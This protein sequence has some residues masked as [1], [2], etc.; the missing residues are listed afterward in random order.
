MTYFATNKGKRKPGLGIRALFVGI[1][2]MCLAIIY[3]TSIHYSLEQNT[4]LRWLFY[5]RGEINAPKDISIVALNSSAAERMGYS[6]HSYTWPRS[7]Y[8]E[9]LG[10]L[11]R[12]NAKLIVLDIAFTEARKEQEDGPF[13]TAL[14]NSNNVILYKYL[15]RHQVATSSGVIDIEEEVPPLQRFLQHALGAGY[16]VLPKE[17]GVLTHA[18]LFLELSRG[19]EASQPVLAFLATQSHV[20]LSR[21]WQTLSGAPFDSSMPI[22][23]QATELYKLTDTNQ[24]TKIP[25]HLQNLFSVFAQRSPLTINFYGQPQSLNHIDIDR[26]LSLDDQE[27]AEWFAGKIVYVGYME[28]KQTEQQDAYS[29]VY[30]SSTGVD[31]SGVEISATVLGNLLNQEYIRATPHYIQFAIT[32]VAFFIGYFSIRLGAK[33][34]FLAQFIC[35][36]TYLM[37]C[38]IL[39][40]VKYVWPPILLP[41]IALLTANLTQFLHNF[42]NNRRKLNQLRFALAQFLPPSAASQLGQSIMSLEKQ[43][44]VVSGVALITDIKGYTRLS[45]TLAPEKLHELMNRYY[46]ILIKVVQKHNGF[47]ANIVGDSLLALWTGPEVDSAL[48]KKSLACAKEMCEAIKKDSEL[49]AQLPTCMALHGGQFSLGNL[50]AAGHFEYSPVGDII[51]TVSRIE[52]FNRNLGTHILFSETIGKSLQGEAGS[53]TQIRFLGAFNMRN[54]SAATPLYTYSLQNTEKQSQFDNA[55]RYFQQHQFSEA[56]SLFE[57]LHQDLQDGPCDYYIRA[58]QQ[59]LESKIQKETDK[60]NLSQ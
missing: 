51:N 37:G 48:C 7:L 23:E 13:E 27:L 4:A 15:K 55:I 20:D 39:F 34:N 59:Q 36:M 29:T 21:L 57:L 19:V 45:E 50:G 14:K 11:S 26:V 47:V 18:H 30:T 28:D 10:A 52:H 2:M 54:K 22:N 1:F 38:Y 8:A 35:L 58:C 44:Q 3:S 32:L 12:A 25:P 41:I 43:Y 9:L 31:I 49:A 56:L 17:A 46:E 5:L 60:A 16:F 24:Q 40:T 42:R 6:R 33:T 53:D